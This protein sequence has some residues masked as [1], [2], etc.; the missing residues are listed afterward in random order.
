MHIYIIVQDYITNVPSCFGASAPSA[1]SFGIV[2]A[3]DTIF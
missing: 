2:L 1:G 3:E